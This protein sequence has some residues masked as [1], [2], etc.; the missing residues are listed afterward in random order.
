[1]LNARDDLGI[2]RSI[3]VGKLVDLLSGLPR[4]HNVIV[5]EVGN[6]LIL[7]GD[8]GQEDSWEE[9]HCIELSSEEIFLMSE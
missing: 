1:M 6:L 9:T 4:D 8:E 7:K 2:W 3:K 5:N